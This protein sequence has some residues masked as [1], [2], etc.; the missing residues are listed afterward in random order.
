M[1]WKLKGSS[2]KK[3]KI[4]SWHCPRWML[5]VSGNTSGHWITA[6]SER[7]PFESAQSKHF[8]YSVL[9]FA[10]S[11]KPI[12]ISHLS[13][14]ALTFLHPEN[15]VS[16]ATCSR[17]IFSVWYTGV[18]IPYFRNTK[19]STAHANCVTCTFCTSTGSQSL[20]TKGCMPA[21]L[22]HPPTLQDHL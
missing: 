11:S 3:K 19:A 16:R 9:S 17:A 1:R 15:S 13:L 21:K 20:N 6:S 2:K 4:L 5:A 22:L 7:S 14:T 18:S 8:E 10:A 12:V